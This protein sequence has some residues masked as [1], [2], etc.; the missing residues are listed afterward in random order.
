MATTFWQTGV[1]GSFSVPSNWVSN[2]VPASGD[3]A[4]VDTGA[5]LIGAADLLPLNLT[6]SIGHPDSTPNGAPQ[7]IVGLLEGGQFNNDLTIDLTTAPSPGQFIDGAIGVQG[8]VGYSGTINVGA[9]DGLTMLIVPGAS[10]PGEFANLGVFNVIGTSGDNAF[11]Q[12]DPFSANTFAAYGTVNVSFGNFFATTPDNGPFAPTGNFNLSNDSTLAVVNTIFHN[13]D[14]TFGD[15]TDSLLLGQDD[16]N[17]YEDFGKIIGFQQGDVIGLLSSTTSPA[18]PAH[19]IYDSATGVL[20]FTDAGDAA[21]GQVTLVG[22]YTGW[23]F[24]VSAGTPTSIPGFADE[25]QVTAV[26]CYCA[27]TMI[28][29]ERGDVA[30]EDLAIGDVVVTASGRSRPIKWIGRRAYAARFARN[31]PNLLPIRFKAGSLGHGV[32]T[33]DLLVSPRHAMFLDGVLVPAEH[34]LNGVTIVSETS[35]DEIRYFHIE[36]DGHDILLAEGAPAESFVDDESRRIF[37]NAH[38]FEN[39]YPEIER[40][41]AAYCAP[42]VECGYALD[43]IRRRLA[44]RAGIAVPAATDFGALNGAIESCDPAGLSGWARSEAFPDAPVCLD[45]SVDGVFLGYAYADVERKEGGRA[46]SLRFAA[47]LDPTRSHV[48]TA[49]R[50]AD[51]AA[52]ASAIVLDALIVAA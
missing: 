26:A 12:V 40:T 5:V 4:V 24:S 10:D 13:T 16:A 19:A 15:A 45:I 2:L 9:G 20:E 1:V 46:F 33:R 25:F 29:T 42:R 28:A 37:Q 32:P 34:L 44:E 3:T 43:R 30:V 51:G 31:N 11:A 6:F 48:I 17:K 8:E 35:F 22:D 36:L 41:E 14:V 21:I 50:S 7:S 47:S 49:R 39:L 27:G 23:T 38:E 52:L 18:I